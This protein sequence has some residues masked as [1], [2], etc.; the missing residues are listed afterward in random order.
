[1]LIKVTGLIPQ[2]QFFEAWAQS[3]IYVCKISTITT[4]KYLQ[5]RKCGRIKIHTKKNV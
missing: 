4:I 3:L 1:M 5:E 2:W